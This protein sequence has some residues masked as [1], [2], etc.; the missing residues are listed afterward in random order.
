MSQTGLQD[1]LVN[2]FNNAPIKKTL[3]LVLEYDA[4]GLA[5]CRLK[6]TPELDHGGGDTHGGILATM[7]DTA[8]WFTVASKCGQA[9]LTS[10]IHVRM[11]QPAKRQDLVA[12][13][14]IVRVGSKS[15]VAE[16]RV[17][18]AG[19]DLVAT[20]TASFAMIGPLPSL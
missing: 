3:G 5:V 2:L 15:A 11:L 8:G 17:H 14:S 19:G 9:V 7:L 18:T 10:D 13:A 4:E 6:R 1:L 16:M 12:T 20:A